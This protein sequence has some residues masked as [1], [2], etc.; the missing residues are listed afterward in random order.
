[1][2]E[3]LHANQD[4]KHVV[5]VNALRVMVVPDSIG[6]LAQGVEIDYFAAGA[7]EAE[8]MD[9]FQKGFALTVDAHLKKF[10]S[11]K[12]LLK[13]RRSVVEQFS[14]EEDCWVFSQVSFHKV[15]QLD[16]SAPELRFDCIKFSRPSIAGSTAN[17]V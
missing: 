2:A 8:A 10:G 11:L 3:T 4:S 12:R 1:M 14:A 5:A 17:F 16:A 9:S 15:A 13:S 7:S 6:F